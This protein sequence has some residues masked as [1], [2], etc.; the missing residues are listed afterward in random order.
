[1]R[2]ITFLLVNFKLGPVAFPDFFKKAARDWWKEMIVDMYKD[3][4][5]DALWIDMN[6]VNFDRDV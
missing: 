2:Y 5:F 3:L 1:M 6:E 4:K